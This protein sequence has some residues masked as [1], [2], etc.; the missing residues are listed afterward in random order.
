MSDDCGPVWHAAWLRGS[1]AR[2]ARQRPWAGAAT[3][4]L[5][6]AAPGAGTGPQLRPSAP[7]LKRYS[8]SAE[9]ADSVAFLR[10]TGLDGRQ[11][12]EHG[13]EPMCDRCGQQFDSDYVNGIE[14][15]YTLPQTDAER[16]A[17]DYEEAWEEEMLYQHLD[18]VAEN[19]ERERMDF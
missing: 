17:R 9:A 12:V 13:L 14:P 5:S 19:K 11:L 8:T 3:L 15:T 16:D 10:T 1:Q 4:A 18:H 7:P 2:L 6:T